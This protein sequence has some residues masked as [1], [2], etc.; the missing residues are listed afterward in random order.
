MTKMTKVVM[1]RQKWIRTRNRLPK[2]GESVWFYIPDRDYILLGYYDDGGQCFME[3][4]DEENPTIWYVFHRDYL[5]T[6]WMPLLKPNM[7]KDLTPDEG[8]Y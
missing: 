1:R 6:H 4:G 2:D 5:C 3:Y 8:R 7:P